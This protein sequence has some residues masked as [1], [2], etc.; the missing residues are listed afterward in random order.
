MKFGACVWPFDWQQP[1]ED[2]VRRIAGLGFRAVELI[3]WNRDVLE[4]YYTRARELGAS[5][6]DSS[7]RQSNWPRRS[8]KIRSR[9]EAFPDSL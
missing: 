4:E 2:T 5:E 3:A 9:V 8:H 7:G 6:R 1:Y